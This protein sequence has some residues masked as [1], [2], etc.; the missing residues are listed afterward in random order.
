MKTKF[1]KYF[2]WETSLLTSIY[3]LTGNE[4]G[5]GAQT[6]D[7]LFSEVINFSKWNPQYWLERIND[8]PSN[9]E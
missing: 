6:V 2:W 3:L 8:Y 7:L 1:L 5:E 9:L 4:W